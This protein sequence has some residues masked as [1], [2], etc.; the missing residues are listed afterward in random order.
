MHS[1]WITLKLVFCLYKPKLLF[2]SKLLFLKK[3]QWLSLFAHLFLRWCL[4]YVSPILSPSSNRKIKQ[5]LCVSLFSCHCSPWIVG[6][7]EEGCL[8]WIPWNQRKC[9]LKNLYWWQFSL[10]NAERILSQKSERWDVG[11]GC[12]AKVSMI[13]MAVLEVLLSLLIWE[14]GSKI[15]M[16]KCLKCA[17]LSFLCM[18]LIHKYLKDT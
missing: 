9:I 7:V 10:R 17:L 18:G 6:K 2:F 3:C 8:P 4:W 13:W 16:F 14:G 11:S 5:Y 1:S 12:D 15:L